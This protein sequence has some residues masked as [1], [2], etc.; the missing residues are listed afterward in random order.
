MRVKKILIPVDFSHLT[1]KLVQVAVDYCEKFG[2]ELI[3]YHAVDER[4]LL[5]PSYTYTLPDYAAV[6]MPEEEKIVEQ[7]LIRAKDALEDLIKKF[8][9]EKYHP[10]QVVEEGVPYL[11]IV[12]Y[13]KGNDIDLI[14]IGS[15]GKTG[16][17]HLLLGSVVD[18]IVHHAEMPVLV[19]RVKR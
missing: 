4:N 15:H 1:E 12:D 13:A 10:E 11:S 2:S 7:L 6:S 18:Y 8:N 17:A 16:I 19:V 3:F 14:I 9:L 5:S